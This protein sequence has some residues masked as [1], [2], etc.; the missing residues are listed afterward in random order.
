[1]LHHTLDP[2]ARVVTD[3]AERAAALVAKRTRY[4][5][6]RMKNLLSGDDSRLRNTWDEICAQV[7]GDQSCYGEEY[8][9]TIDSVILSELQK[10]PA[11]ELR[12]LWLQT[13]EGEDRRSKARHRSSTVADRPVDDEACDSESARADRDSEAIPLYVE[14]IIPTISQ[15]VYELAEDWSNRRIRAYLRADEDY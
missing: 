2:D 1:M 6:Q 10:L 4:R 13:D 12:A 14:D 7:Q 9:H 3:L 11:V 8:E 5:L 15:R